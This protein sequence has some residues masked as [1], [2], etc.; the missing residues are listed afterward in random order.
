MHQI[1]FKMRKF[2]PKGHGRGS[3][4]THR[5]LFLESPKD[6]LESKHWKWQGQKYGRKWVCRCALNAFLLVKM[7]VPSKSHPL[8]ILEAKK[9]KDRNTRGWCVGHSSTWWA[10]LKCG[11]AW[12]WFF[13]R[14]WQLRTLH[15]MN[16]HLYFVY[17]QQLDNKSFCRALYSF[18]P[19]YTA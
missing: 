11:I 10:S 5:I 12:G 8:F 2:L 7:K 9:S 6:G 18:H 4:F 17:A 15:A 16:C 3:T 1:L 13:L 14:G 19:P